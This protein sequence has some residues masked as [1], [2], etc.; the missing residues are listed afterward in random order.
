MTVIK[1]FITDNKFEGFLLGSS[2]GET[3]YLTVDEY[4]TYLENT[5]KKIFVRFPNESN[6][7]EIK[8]DL[9]KVEISN[10]FEYE[11]FSRYNDITLALKKPLT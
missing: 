4:Q 1:S 9:S 8:L 2:D 7:E 6:Y 3:K 10:E 5:G 11:Y